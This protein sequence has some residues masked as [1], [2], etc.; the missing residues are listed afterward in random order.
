L[1]TWRMTGISL[2]RQLPLASQSYGVGTKTRFKKTALM[3]ICKFAKNCLRTYV[4]AAQPFFCQ[5]KP[6]DRLIGEAEQ[7]Y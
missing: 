2:H 7:K 3:L 6:G 5:T 4:N 1:L